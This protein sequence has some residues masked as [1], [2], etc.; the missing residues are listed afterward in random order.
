MIEGTGRVAIEFAPR[1]DFGRHATH[2][3][4]VADG[5][6][7]EG[8]LDPV[9]LRSP[10]IRWNLTEDGPH[11][12]AVADIEL[13]GKPVVLELRY[14]ISNA[15]DLV[16]S[17]DKR[18]EQTARFWESWAQ[19]LQLPSLFANEVRRS[20]LVLKALSYGPTGAI[21]AAATTSLPEHIGGIRNWDYRYCW[22]RD[23]ALS[24]TALVRLG[25]SG[26]GT[27]LVDWILGIMDREESPD[28]FR[29][30]YT[31][32]GGHLGAEADIRE[33]S[34][35]RG[36]RPVRVGNA[37][38][39]QLQL[40]VFGPI[41]E[42]LDVL[43]ESGVAFSNEH[44]RLTQSIVNAVTARWHEPDHGI[45][46]IRG[47]QQ[48][49]VHS[50]VM[51]W[52]AVDRALKISRAFTGEQPPEWLE[53]RRTI[54]DDV[55][56]RGWSSTLNAFAATY[57]LHAPDAATLHIGLSG[58]LPGSDS[59]F[60]STVEAVERSLRRGPTVYRYHYDDALP[61]REGGFH[62]C[63]AWLIESLVMI[64]QTG[65]AKALLEDFIGL[66]GPTGLGPEEYC[67]KTQTSLGNHPQAYTHIG[68]INAALAVSRT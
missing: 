54:A 4:E 18:M 14:G 44:W 52:M 64:G 32:T 62:F 48:H 23:A 36:S 58:L 29:P 30:V 50:K 67:P 8:S 49:H 1:L 53:L 7:I 34:G 35:Y 3:R 55:L 59:R 28:Q 5:L 6:R 26:I 20:A 9:V 17:T 46:E 12:R 27:R 63:T 68:M 65:R 13:T 47:P 19:S 41:M 43:T 60:V 2:L 66:L 56:N 11:Q 21:A 24:A 15:H 39:Q 61:G 37:A 40:D 51:C 42:L 57:D 22:L 31:M 33:L 16:V 25:S 10:G 45:W 38:A